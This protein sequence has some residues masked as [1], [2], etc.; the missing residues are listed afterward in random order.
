[1]AEQQFDKGKCSGRERIIQATKMLTEERTFDDITIEEII[2]TAELSRP[3]FYYHFTDGK[4]ELRAELIQRGLLEAKPLQDNR[5]AILEAAVRIFARSGVS[6]ATLD[7]IAAEAG[8]T[9]GALLWHFHTKDDLLMAIIKNCG[10]HSMIRPVI[11][12]IEQDIQ[13]GLALNDECIIRRLA[14]AFYDGFATQ[15]DITRLAFLVIYTHPQAARMLADTIGKGRK[16]FAE[17]I[18]R[19]QDEGYFR[20]DIDP[21]LFAQSVTMI[22]AMRAISRGLDDLLPFAHLSREEIIDQLVSLLL[23]GIVRRD[24]LPSGETNTLS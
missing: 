20:N 23:Y 9:R 11:D 17:Y 10:P 14:A 15:S 13:N 24:P 2:K 18:K 12:Q 3:A 7:D 4:E 19:R 6:A 1:M 8:V 16:R 21:G 22:F 5:Q